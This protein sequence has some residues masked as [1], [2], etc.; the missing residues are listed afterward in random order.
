MAEKGPTPAPC[1]ENQ[2][3][4]ILAVS[5]SLLATAIIAVLLRLHIRLGLSN[6]LDADDY[7]IAASL[8][9]HLLGKDPFEKS[10]DHCS[11]CCNHRNGFPD[12][13]GRRGTWETHLVFT[14][15]PP[16]SGSKMEYHRADMQRYRDW[17][18]Q[19]IR[20]TLRSKDHRQDQNRPCS[21]PLRRD[22]LCLCEPSVTGHPLYRPMQTNGRDLESAYTGE[23]LLPTYH[24]PSRLHRLR[25]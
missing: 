24:L 23:M 17:T 14:S 19:N 8:A 18:C 13:I 20:Y 25:A 16:V 5:F 1:D 15:R 3:P 2:G 22:C 4:M 10:S 11:G 6:G 7:T 21:L 12:Q 9:S